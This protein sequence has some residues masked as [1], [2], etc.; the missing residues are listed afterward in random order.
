[1]VSREIEKKNWKIW[2]KSVLLKLCVY[3]FFVRG[4]GVRVGLIYMY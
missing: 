1:M 2:E 3:G 4:L